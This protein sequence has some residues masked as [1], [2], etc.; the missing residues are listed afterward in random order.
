MPNSSEGSPAR[1]RR[2]SGKGFSAFSLQFLGY[3][4]GKDR[5]LRR[6]HRTVPASEPAIRVPAPAS[7]ASK[8]N[9]GRRHRRRPCQTRQDRTPDVTRALCRSVVEMDNDAL[10]AE[11]AGRTDAATTAI[12]SSA[13]HMTFADIASVNRALITV[14][15]GTVRNFFER[16]HTV[17]ELNDLRRQL[18]A[19]CSIYLA[20]ANDVAV[21]YSTAEFERKQHRIS[22]RSFRISR[23]RGPGQKHLISAAIDPSTNEMAPA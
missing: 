1:P 5:F 9:R 12:F 18:V 17:R 6:A 11:F 3:R 4:L 19:M 23:S 8:T 15:F 2:D 22:L 7:T 20:T 14:I 21:G 16:S 10:I 13:S